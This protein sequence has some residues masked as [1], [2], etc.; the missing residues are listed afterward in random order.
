MV[1]KHLVEHDAGRDLGARDATCCALLPTCST[2]QPPP[3]GAVARNAGE[4]QV[5]RSGGAAWRLGCRLAGKESRAQTSSSA[6]WRSIGAGAGA[7]RSGGA[8]ASNTHV[9]RASTQQRSASARSVNASGQ[10]S[11]NQPIGP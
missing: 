11:R 1:R 5:T 4:L 3:R 10:R 6:A 9:Q 7:A 8:G 2:A